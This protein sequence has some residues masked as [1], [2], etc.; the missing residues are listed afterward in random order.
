M[1][2]IFSKYYH[3]QNDELLG[4]WLFFFATLPFIPYSLVFL[5][6]AG[7]HGLI[8]LGMLGLAIFVA[9]ACFLFVLACYPSTADVQVVSCA[10]VVFLLLIFGLCRDV[11]QTILHQHHCYITCLVVL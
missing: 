6:N 5:A 10:V 2:P 7:Y 9:F 1:R 8:F 11:D 3:V 4:S